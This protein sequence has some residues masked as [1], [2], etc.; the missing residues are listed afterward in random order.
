M[1]IPVPVRYC[2]CACCGGCERGVR[3]VRGVRGEL[4]SASPISTYD[5]LLLSLADIDEDADAPVNER[6]CLVAR[7]AGTHTS[8]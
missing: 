7:G 3:G 5:P 2:A 1:P 4:G 6:C 8:G